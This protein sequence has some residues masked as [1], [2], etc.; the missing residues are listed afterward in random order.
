LDR[1]TAQRYICVYRDQCLLQHRPVCT[2]TSS[3]VSNSQSDAS[4]TLADYNGSVVKIL[5][6]VG[7]S[8]DAESHEPHV[9]ENQASAAID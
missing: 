8:V 3:D 5:E 1:S 9:S 2:V 4:V 6:D 7:T